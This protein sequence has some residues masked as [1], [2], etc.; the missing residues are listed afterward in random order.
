[1]SG[2][3][4]RGPQSDESDVQR[5]AGTPYLQR[6]V[7]EYAVRLSAM[8]GT[9]QRLVWESSNSNGDVAPQ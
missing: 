2:C 8:V 4:C 3:V 5:G 6:I 1:M 9:I 7:G